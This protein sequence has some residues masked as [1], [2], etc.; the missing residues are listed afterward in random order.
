[1]QN[2]FLAMHGYQ[3]MS[4]IVYFIKLLNNDMLKPNKSHNNR[5]EIIHDVLRS[6]NNRTKV[7]RLLEEIFAK[8]NSNF[9]FN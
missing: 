7:N 2:N 5:N 3:E 4:K 1:M 8:L 9:N 6:E